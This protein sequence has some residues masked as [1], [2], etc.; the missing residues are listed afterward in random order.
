M[1]NANKS[2]LINMIRQKKDQFHQKHICILLPTPPLPVIKMLYEEA[3]CVSGFLR[4]V[5]G[6]RQPN[7]HFLDP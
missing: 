7:P 6:P 1:M 3:E 4:G 2:S 5:P